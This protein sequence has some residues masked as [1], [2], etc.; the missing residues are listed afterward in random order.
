[1]KKRILNCS[2]LLIVFLT[3]VFTAVTAVK[4]YNREVNYDDILI[5]LGAGITVIVGGFAVIYELDLFH[6]VKYFLF[7][8]KTKAK[9][10]LNVFANISLITVFVYAVLSYTHMGLRKYGY[11]PLLLVAV[12]VIIR[13]A[14]LAVSGRQMRKNADGDL[15]GE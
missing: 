7:K 2:F 5:G 9:T 3:V 10:L 14:Y 8:P 4:T 6:T 13:I 11:V 12:Y 15:S 1:M